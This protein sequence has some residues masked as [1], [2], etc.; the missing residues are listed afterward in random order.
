MD[1]RAHVMIIGGVLGGLIG[2]VAAQVYL[3]SLE[4]R[5]GGDAELA[6]ASVE[7]GDLIKL[8]LSVLGLLKMVDRLAKSDD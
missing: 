4:H 6:R 7:P 2:L 8:T 1:K 3:R 5:S